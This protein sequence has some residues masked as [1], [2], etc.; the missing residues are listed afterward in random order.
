MSKKKPL[1]NQVVSG[2]ASRLGES[3]KAVKTIN[4][5]KVK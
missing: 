3:V 2:T 1:V 5:G 4:T